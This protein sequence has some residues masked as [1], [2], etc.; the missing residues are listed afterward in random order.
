MFYSVCFV[1]SDGVIWTL[2]FSFIFQPAPYL[3]FQAGNLRS[4]CL[5]GRVLSVFFNVALSASLVQLVSIPQ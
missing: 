4:V 3:D 1:Y 5:I 2:W